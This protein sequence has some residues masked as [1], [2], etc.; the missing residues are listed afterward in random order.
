[1]ILN[2][3]HDY[4]VFRCCADG[5][6]EA[7]ADDSAGKSRTP[8]S[9]TTSPVLKSSGAAASTGANSPDPALKGEEVAAQTAGE[10]PWI[11]LTESWIE[12]V[13]R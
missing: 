7:E 10:E 6:L 2:P 12:R 3:V 9:G 5:G 4:R 1:V 11:A 8:S 13:W